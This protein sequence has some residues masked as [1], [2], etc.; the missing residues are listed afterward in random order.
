V[1]QTTQGH[2]TNLASTDIE[3]FEMMVLYC[4]HTALIH[5]THTLHSHTALPHCTCAT[6]DHALLRSNLV[7]HRSPR[8]PPAALA[9]GGG[10]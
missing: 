1:Q 4:I 2:I 5:C 6:G 10:Q 9:G 8:V 3:R 7:P